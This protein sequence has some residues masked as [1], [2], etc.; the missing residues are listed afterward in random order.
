MFFNYFKKTFLLIILLCVIKSQ[1]VLNLL[2]FL[3]SR[4]S[5]ALFPSGVNYF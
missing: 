1:E 3:S 2:A 4:A 5:F